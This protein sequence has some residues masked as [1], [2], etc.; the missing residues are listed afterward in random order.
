MVTI[1]QNSK[2]S[3]LTKNIMVRFPTIALKI[4]DQLGNDD[5]A[6]C[7]K[8]NESSRNFIDNQKLPWIRMIQKY[9][10][11]TSEFLHDWKQVTG[12]TPTRIVKE[13]AIQTELFFK[14]NP[15]RQNGNW[16]P[17]FIVADQ[18]DLELYQYIVDKTG[19]INPKKSD[20]NRLELH[21]FVNARIKNE[22]FEEI[23]SPFEMAI[24]KGKVM[25]SP[26]AFSKFSSSI[27]KFFKHAQFFVYTQNHFGILKS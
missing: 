11:N 19:C 22:N 21:K 4:F 26:S 27:L 2:H 1:A 3:C 13:L 8:L 24:I 7:R 23:P 9:S 17:H 25:P 14:S 18:G 12:K 15:E 5:L 16:A 20:R 10:S 6:N